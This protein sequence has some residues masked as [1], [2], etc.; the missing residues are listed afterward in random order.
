MTT[1]KALGAVIRKHAE[2]WIMETCP[3]Y[4]NGEPYEPDLDKP[5]LTP[6]P[7]R[8]PLGRGAIV[9]PVSLH[10]L[11]PKLRADVEHAW[12]VPG[13]WDACQGEQLYMPEDGLEYLLGCLGHLCAS[14]YRV[15]PYARH[16]EVPEKF[17]RAR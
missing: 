4:R 10:P 1:A 14:G 5:V 17:L 3:L 9:D 12:G 2:E 13:L 16:V 8:V 6:R 7:V 11:L 15:E